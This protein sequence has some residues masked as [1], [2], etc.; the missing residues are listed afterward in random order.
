[1]LGD[2]L[3]KKSSSGY[4]R[5]LWIF[6]ICLGNPWC[7]KE[8]KQLNLP[9]LCV[10]RH[11]QAHPQYWHHSWGPITFLSIPWF[12]CKAEKKGGFTFT[13][14]PITSALSA[15]FSDLS[16]SV[17]TSTHS[18]SDKA[19]QRT[20][21]YSGKHTHRFQAW[22]LSGPWSREWS[23]YL[24][25]RFPSRPLVLSAP[26]CFASWIFSFPGLQAKHREAGVSR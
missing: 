21:S 16:R 19:M 13:T 4:S 18:D 3:P 5:R 12:D 23:P 2:G 17:W 11:Q 8:L 15:P 22:L 25:H 20:K 10:F 9:Q 7:L 6:N 26:L 14:T 24:Y 1:M